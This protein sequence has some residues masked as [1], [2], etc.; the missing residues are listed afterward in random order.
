MITLHVD[1]GRQWR[2][3]QSQALLLMRGLLER[4]HGAELV[5]R[6]GSPLAVRALAAGVKV[7]PLWHL[8]HAEPYALVHCHDAHGLTAAWAAGAARQSR[9]V[10]SRRVA[11][12]LARNPLAKARYRAA[13]IVAVSNFVRASVIA[14]G[15][16]A[17]QVDVV[18][19]GVELPELAPPPSASRR[20]GC[21][22]YLLPEKGQELLIRAL[23]LVVARYPDASLLLAGDGP[24]RVRLERLASELGIAQAVEFAGHVEDV[25]AVYRSLDVFL[26]PS[27][28]EPLGSALLTA[29]AYGLPVVARPSGAVPEVIEDGVNGLF[30]GEAPGAFAGAVLRVLDDAELAARLGAA[31]RLAVEQRFSADAMIEGTL[32]VYH[33][34]LAC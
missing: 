12:P 4:G 22:G 18:Y 31:A 8:L 19:D 30:G 32:Q 33:R 3:G 1:L 21:V 27:L 7:H 29:M 9:L 20:L 15:V 25:A 10:A 26:F 5:A 34:V 11:Y 14:S 6:A 16:P 17:A 23:P 2:G 28:A 24:C 13:R